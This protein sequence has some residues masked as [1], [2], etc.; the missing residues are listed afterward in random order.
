MA[1][2]MARFGRGAGTHSSN[3]SAS[4]DCVFWRPTSQCGRL[5]LLR[6][7]RF[8][9]GPA[10]SDRVQSAYSSAQLMVLLNI[11]NRTPNEQAVIVALQAVVNYSESKDFVETISH[12]LTVLQ[13]LL[14]TPAQ[15]QDCMLAPRALSAVSR[16]SPVSNEE[17]ERKRASQHDIDGAPN[18]SDSP[19]S[20]HPPDK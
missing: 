1:L 17:P 11:A 7:D 5:Y 18:C 20:R 12:T 3:M 10:F 4:R 14:D 2:S 8:L 16:L 15:P 13:T 9:A 19:T 6:H